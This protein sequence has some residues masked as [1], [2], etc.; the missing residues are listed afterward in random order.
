MG[1][2]LYNRK[3]KQI[4]QP[5]SLRQVVVWNGINITTR[6]AITFY[7]IKGQSFLQ[8]QK[9]REAEKQRGSC[10][11][12]TE[13]PAAVGL[14]MSS[15]LFF[16]VSLACIRRPIPFSIHYFQFTLTLQ[17]KYLLHKSQPN[18]S[19]TEAVL[20]PVTTLFFWKHSSR[21]GQHGLKIS[22]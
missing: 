5:Q 15:P 1:P 19:Q 13:S 11:S 14:S 21:A 17:A 20:Y 12:Q 4:S 22:Q 9:S 16:V 7:T 8:R 6:N 10:E 3:L 18:R 2:A